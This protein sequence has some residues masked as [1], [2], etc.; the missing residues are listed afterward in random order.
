MPATV[1]SCVVYERD[2][3]TAQ[4]ILNRPRKKN[5]INNA[6]LGDIEAA[7][8]QGLS[9]DA[10]RSIVLVGAGECFTSGRDIKE[11]SENAALHDGSLEHVQQAFMRVLSA[12]CDAPKPTIAAVKGFALG[13][14][15]ALSLACD[16]VVAERGAK[17]G[18]V[19]MAYGFPA[20]MN[21]ALLARHL[22]RRMGLEIALTGQTYS[23]ERYFD[24][25]LVNRLAEPGQLEAATTAFAELL[26]QHPPWAVARTK[27]TFR[28][29]EES[30]MQ[31][32]FHIGSQLNQLLMLSSQQEPV[33]SADQSS[34]AAVKDSIAGK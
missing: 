18:N 10:V 31:V 24:L 26:N 29:A 1:D 2:G 22:G 15:Q 12:L 16:F 11:F 33:H 21:I 27:A 6:M 8:G 5:A 3:A 14:G 7:I 34:K 9:D 32:S 25:G 17:F 30:T 20:A 28:V 19:E 4:I 13:G 23:A